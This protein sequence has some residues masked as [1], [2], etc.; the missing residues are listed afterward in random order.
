MPQRKATPSI[1]VIS[2]DPKLASTRKRALEKAGFKV[3]PATSVQEVTDACVKRSIHMAIIGYSLF[4]AE[5]RRIG[6]ALKESCK[7][8]V[9]ELHRVEGPE[10][11]HPTQPLHSDEFI[12][13]VKEILRKS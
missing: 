3:I 5:K 8:P 1:L 12:D 11:V 9:L 4:P 13:S 10:L 6:N 7:V 2:R